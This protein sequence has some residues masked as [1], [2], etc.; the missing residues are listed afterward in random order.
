[1]SDPVNGDNTQNGGWGFPQQLS[2]FFAGEIS[3][4]MGTFSQIT[5][6]H[7][8]D[9]FSIDNVDFRYANHGTVGGTNA[10]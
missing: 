6:T 4:H 5:Y 8:D 2:F 3:D 1:L 7:A 10:I 9:H